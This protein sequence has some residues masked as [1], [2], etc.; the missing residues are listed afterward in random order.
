MSQSMASWAISCALSLFK[1]RKAP[2]AAAATEPQQPLTRLAQQVQ[3]CE[4]TTAEPVSASLPAL[5]EE[6]R[7]RLRRQRCSRLNQSC[8][9]LP[10]L[11]SRPPK[12]PP[13]GPA[14]A[15]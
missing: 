15:E 11:A 3:R 14:R 13:G 10:G 5:P 7:C 8:A 1:R 9:H 6:V 2:V 4:S 12:D